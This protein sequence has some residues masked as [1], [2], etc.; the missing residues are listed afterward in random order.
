MEPV[1]ER[2]IDEKYWWKHKTVKIYYDDDPPDPRDFDN[3]GTI[4]AWH[5]SYI[6]DEDGRKEFG[7]PNDFLLWE[8]DNECVFLPVFLLDHSG[9]RIST[10]SSQFRAVDQAGWDWGQL[11]WIYI[12]RHD[13]EKEFAS[14]DI[15]WSEIEERSEK[16]LR[17]DIETLDDVYTGNVLGFVI[18]DG[19]GNHVDSCWG[20]Y[21]YEPEKLADEIVAGNV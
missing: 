10:T 12:T 6:F 1:Y 17:Q 14:L 7:E 20:F 11:G 19:E 15:P 2:T 8:E 18:E 4:V 21:G 13:A 16:I 5:N 3:L 9:L